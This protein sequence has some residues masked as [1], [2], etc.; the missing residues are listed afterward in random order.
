MRIP[1]MHGRPPRLPGSTVIRSR[2]SMVTPCF[3]NDTR[4][5]IQLRCDHVNTPQNRDHIADRVSFDHLRKGLIV[6]VAWRAGAGAPGD[7][8]AVAD[9][10][11][12]QLPVP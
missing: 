7:V 1:R 3:P 5:A 10:V 4:S 11:V 8:V 9:D 6:D 12:A 2:S